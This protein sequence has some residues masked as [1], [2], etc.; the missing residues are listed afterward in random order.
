[1]PEARC[2]AAVLAAGA[3]TRM[4]EPKQLISAYGESLLRRSV[5][6]ASEA[7]FAPVYVVLGAYADMMRRELAG[8]TA[9]IVMNERWQ[10]GMGTSLQ[11]AV[12]AADEGGATDLLMMTC[13][14]PLLSAE[15]LRGLREQ[16]ERREREATAARYAAGNVGV[17]AVF[18]RRWFPALLEIEGDRGARALLAQRLGDVFAVE[19]AGGETD[20]DSPEDLARFRTQ[21]SAHV[22]GE[23][24]KRC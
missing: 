19:F 5:R 13:D 16:H 22:K 23:E 1:M 8:S 7:G 14:Q 11:C 15:W 10:E 17:P 9:V 6:I 2:A 18:P 4:G 20:L 24:R 21:R 12:R 3:S